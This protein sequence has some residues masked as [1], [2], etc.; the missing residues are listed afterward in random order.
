LH[1]LENKKPALGALLV[2]LHVSGQFFLVQLLRS[3]FVLTLF[4]D[5]IVE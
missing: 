3:L 4:I 5:Q 1:D 2:R